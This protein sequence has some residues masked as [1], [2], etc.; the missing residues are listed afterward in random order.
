MMVMRG[1]VGIGDVIVVRSGHTRID[2]MSRMFGA[3]DIADIGSQRRTD[4]H[5]CECERQQAPS[6][7]SAVYLIHTATQIFGMCNYARSTHINEVPMAQASVTPTKF[8]CA[9]PI[10]SL[11]D[12]AR[13]IRY[14]VDVL[15]FSPTE[16]A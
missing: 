7:R 11:R 6:H 2:R 4:D 9:S 10:L 16:P 13:S 8:E 14:Y 5:E 15:G 3:R 12:M 1:L